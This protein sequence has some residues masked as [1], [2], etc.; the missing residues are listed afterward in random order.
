VL[1]VLFPRTPSH[2]LHQL[3]TDRA[4]DGGMTEGVRNQIA[5]TLQEFGF[6]P[7]GCTRVS[8]KP[9]LEYFDTIPYTRG[10]R[11]PDFAKFNGDDTKT[12]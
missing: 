5:R 1:H 7:M 4:N 6:M 10:F 3:V 12:T 2:T 11:V 9:Y 8:K